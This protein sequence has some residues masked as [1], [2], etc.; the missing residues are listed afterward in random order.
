MRNAGIMR[1]VFLGAA[2]FGVGGA[3]V[4][5]V[6]SLWPPEPVGLTLLV[7]GGVIGG[8]SLGLA[9]KAIR[10]TIALALLGALG[11]TFGIIVA[12]I[13][14]FL[15]FVPQSELGSLGAMGAIAG[16]IGGASLGLALW[17]WKRI[18]PLTLAGAVGLGAG[19]IVVIFSRRVILGGS[20]LLDDNP[21]ETIILFAVVGV[22]AGA[23][24]GATLGYLE[25]AGQQPRGQMLLRIAALASVPLIGV[26]LFAG[27]VLPY[28]SICG[29]E[30]R[31]ALSEFPQYGGIEK[32]PGPSSLGEGCALFYNTSAPPEKVAA[33]FAEQL[34]EH[35][36]EVEHQLKAKGD[37]SEQFGG[38][39]VTAYRD[40]LRY[41]AGYESLEFY[42]P[43]RPGTHVA[44]HVFED[45][46]KKKLSCGSEEK[47][48]LAEFPHYGG[49]E[50]GNRPLPG[51]T[52]GACVI[53]YP[54][55]GASRE[56]VSAYYE[57]KLAEHGWKVEQST[58]ET[59][60]SRDGLRYVVHYWR[61][62]DD[63]E[64][65]VQVFEAE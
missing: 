47:A 44:V 61:N 28:R 51:K 42:D 53:S 17:D 38:T 18:M 50:L 65:E 60:A 34:E 57:E 64:V 41:D 33:Y 35:G 27:F 32:E 31:T 21:A 58:D 63:T 54:A 37:G 6:A 5:A 1:F 2:G 46:R 23:S 29:E 9:L 25:W 24:L 43:P 45:R 48:A 49:K 10:K 16:A 20:F 15:G 59:R 39:L 12:F 36:W 8:A 3:I 40:G 4:G 14:G 22:I 56:Q 13:V 30:Q 26:L 62:P 7:L 11:F 52:K 19:A 55:K